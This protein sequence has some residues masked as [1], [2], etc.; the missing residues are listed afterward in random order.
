MRQIPLSWLG[1]KWLDQSENLTPRRTQVLRKVLL[2]TASLCLVTPA[3]A[4][5]WWVVDGS[6]ECVSEPFY[7]PASAYEHFR[8]DKGRNPRIDDRGGDHVFVGYYDDK[9]GTRWGYNFY[10]TKEA[11]EK[12]A[13]LQRKEKE[14]LDKYR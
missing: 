12:G 10:K 7:T 3:L 11:C 6:N 9:R 1:S 14:E 5:Q 8:D 4:I 13:E 2:T